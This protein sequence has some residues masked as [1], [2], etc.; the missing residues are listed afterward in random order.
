M[1]FQRADSLHQ[2][3]LKIITNAHN[4]SG[5][6]HLRSQ[7]TFRTDKFIKWKP[8]YFNHTIIKHRFKTRIGLFC[9]CVFNLVQRITESYLRRNLCNRITCR[10]RCKRRRTA[11]TGI[12][13]YDAILESIRMKGIL[14][15]A[16][17]GDI[18]LTDNI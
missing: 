13:F 18:Q 11:D 3:P 15:V 7:R 5:R 10:L 8:G 16:P 6:L 1:L 2:R 12:Y 14:Y 17:S 4:L 9:H